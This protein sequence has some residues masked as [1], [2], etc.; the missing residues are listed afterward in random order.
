MPRSSTKP[1]KSEEETPSHSAE[2]EQQA[3]GSNSNSPVEEKKEDSPSGEAEEGASR[4]EKDDVEMHDEDGE[5]QEENDEKNDEENDDGNEDE[6]DESKEGEGHPKFSPGSAIDPVY[7]QNLMKPLFERR[8]KSLKELLDA[9]DEFSPIIPDAVID[10]YLTKSGFKSNDPRIKRLLALATQ[11]FVAD[12]VNDAY[13]FA[14]IRAQS[15]TASGGAGRGRAGPGSMSGRT[16]LTMESLSGVLGDY[17]I[18]ASK[19]DFY[20]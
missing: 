13:Q 2:H 14:K 12:I 18:N 16:V 1:V 4:Q 6:N 11:K 20:R 10:Y 8:D 7:E 15:A 19:P 3:E 17:G 5:K 9:M